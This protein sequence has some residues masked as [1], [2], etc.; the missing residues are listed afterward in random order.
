MTASASHL[1][2]LA[3]RAAARARRDDEHAGDR[4]GTRQIA[5]DRRVKTAARDDLAHEMKRILTT[6][7]PPIYD[8]TG[9][10]G[11]SERQIVRI[12]GTNFPALYRAAYDAG[13][14]ST[15]DTLRELI[16][17]AVADG[18]LR[19]DTTG[20]RTYYHPSGH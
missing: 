18:Q 12:R 2:D 7:L 15:E 4:R 1:A 14:L 16:E 8:E 9:G 19:A 3:T 13:G 5:A 11:L 10:R 20:D 17:L 6:I